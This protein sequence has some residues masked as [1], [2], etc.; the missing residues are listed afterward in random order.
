M[1]RTTD[2]LR[3]HGLG[4]P[5]P[6]P[7]GG[8]VLYWMQTA[9]RA[10]WNPALNFAIE[11]ANRMR[12][13]VA[14]HHE[15][16]LDYPWAS[17]RI[18]TFILESV[19]DLYVD[20]EGLGIAY[21]FH[22]HRGPAGPDAGAPLTTLAKGAALV[23]TDLY[24]LLE[25]PGRIREL[26]R[27]V[28]T[29]V[30]AVDGCTVVPLNRFGREFS[31][32]RAMRPRLLEALPHYLHP[33]P[34][35]DVRRRHRIEFPFEPVRPTAATIPSLV[36]GCVI[37]HTVPPSPLI[38]GGRRAALTRLDAFLRTGLV[39]YSRDRGDPNAEVTSRLSPYLH[40]GNVSINE[41]LLAVRAAAP[42]A[43]YRKFLDEALVWR[44]LAHN[45]AWR[46]PACRTLDAVPAWA[47]RELEDHVR[48]PRPALYDDS[49]LDRGET[50]DELWNAAQQS[51]RRDGELHNYVRMLW[52]KA[53]I[54]WKR[55]PA[56]AL[57]T[58][59]HLNHRYAL[60]GRDPCSYGGIL[61]CFGKFDRPFF[62]RPIWGT[63]RYMSLTAA[64][65]KFDVDRYVRR[66]TER[67]G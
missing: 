2:S 4:E 47:R 18:H 7:G 45:L 14:V 24:P 44:E 30:V 12:L 52:G 37:D 34:E 22:L 63:V 43:E 40:F 64:R 23:V 41:V 39:H 50:G 16:R 55:T 1:W 65:R 13:P 26:R 66:R 11:Q 21:A 28:E 59:E 25:V 29:P 42:D 46:N 38:R 57:R 56:E 48:D 3:I 49:A 20:F 17:D 31:T 33:V 62:R 54:G 8:F 36:A 32:A 5:P 10:R 67:R 15:L 9:L 61:W 60:D 35:P 27:R 58:L 53:V 19:A 6:R 51:L